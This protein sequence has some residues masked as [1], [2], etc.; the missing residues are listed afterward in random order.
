MR[1][2]KVRAM[3]GSALF[4]VPT[5]SALAQNA[6]GDWPY[7]RRRTSGRARKQRPVPSATVRYVPAAAVLRGP[8]DALALLRHHAPQHPSAVDVLARVQQPVVLGDPPSL[9]FRQPL[10]HA[11]RCAVQEHGLLDL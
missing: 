4:M 6:R 1:P 2:V 3:A 7:V 9:V 10:V 11:R 5:I 8:P